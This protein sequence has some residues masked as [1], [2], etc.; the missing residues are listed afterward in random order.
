MKNLVILVAD[1]IKYDY[2]PKKPNI[3]KYFDNGCFFGH[4]GDPMSKIVLRSWVGNLKLKAILWKE[5]QV[6][7]L[8][9]RMISLLGRI[10]Q[11]V[12][13]WFKPILSK[14]FRSLYSKVCRRIYSSIKE[15]LM[16]SPIGFYIYVNYRDRVE[17][18]IAN[19]NWEMEYMEIFYRSVREGDVVVDVAAHI[20]IYSL[21]A[22]GRVGNRGC[23]YAFEPIP[24]NYERLMRNVEVDQAKNIRAYNLGLSDRD[25]ILSFSVPRE[26]PAE[27]PLVGSWTD[28]PGALK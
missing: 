23:V 6:N 1:S 3:F 20:G 4:P 5:T 24:G 18:K 11:Y 15:E 9:H 13:D 27:S 2:L 16:K 25:E 21:L 19:G 14:T 22:S 10:P 17:R 8:K 26:I 7:A 28:S 12:P